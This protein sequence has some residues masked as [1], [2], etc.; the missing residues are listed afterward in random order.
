MTPSDRRLHPVSILFVLVAQLRQFALPGIVVL[1]TAGSAGLNWQVWPLLLV[2]PYTLVAILRYASFRYRY[3]PADIV[4]QTG[5]IF[6]NERHV[7]Y[8]RIQNLDAVQN[9]LHR[10]FRVVDVRL[11]T[12]GGQE[13]EARLTVL[14]VRAFEEMRQR[15]LE[16]RARAGVG[17]AA[18]PGEPESERVLLRLSL[19]DLALAGL[20]ENRGFVIIAAAFGVLWEF[21]VMDRLTE[22]AFGENAQARGLI[23]DVLRSIYVDGRLP[24]A[25]I[26]F[27]AGAFAAFLLVVRVLSMI[28][29]IVRLHGFTLAREAEDLHSTFGLFTRVE[30]TIP[31]RRVQT[32]T[33]R[34]GPLHRWFGRASVRVETAGGEAGAERGV[35]QREWLAPIIARDELPRFVAEVLPGLD[36]LRI[37]WHGVAPGAFRRALRAGLVVAFTIALSLVWLLRW[38]DLALLALLVAWA[39]V[40]S[41]TYVASLRWG[42]TD[43]AIGFRSGWIWRQT[44]LARFNRIQTVALHES[45]FDRRH[46][47]ARVRVDT[48]GASEASHRIDIPYLERPV[49]QGLFTTLAARAEATVFRW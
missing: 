13:P 36:L 39:A 5:F 44:T 17:P 2:V 31:S 6:R 19:S 34:E 24:V 26:A 9:V 25:R 21:G 27:A 33:V 48:A 11:E 15:V 35:R 46:A 37:D 14:P 3:E 12:G 45:P 20:I 7:P 4:I 28:W 41:R 43:D 22:W 32:L 16:E 49:A 1:V 23:R 29:A 47:M 42:T 38:W 30:A 10:L 8:A 40:G 18:E